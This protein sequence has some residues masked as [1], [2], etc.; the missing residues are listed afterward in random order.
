MKRFLSAFIILTLILV[1]L[2]GCSDT[3]SSEINISPQPDIGDGNVEASNQLGHIDEIPDPDGYGFEAQYIRTDGGADSTRYPQTVVINSRKELE[4]YYESNRDIYDLER[5]DMVS[6]DSTIGFLDACDRYDDAYFERQQLVI[7]L[8]EEPSG[9]NRH[10]ITDVRRDFK[11]GGWIVSIRRLIP[12]SG[13]DDM[14]QWHLLLEIEMGKVIDY[15]EN[16][17]VKLTSID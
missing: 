13:T 16:I 10:R 6:L 11:N 2:A 7:I 8:Q 1:T 3:T 4:D 5:R 17:N 12:E 15:G 9:S 14:A